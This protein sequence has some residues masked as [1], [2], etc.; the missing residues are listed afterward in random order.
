MSGLLLLDLWEVD[1]TVLAVEHVLARSVERGGLAVWGRKL[2]VTVCLPNL[3]FRYY[4]EF[5]A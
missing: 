5:I 2:Q 4:T 3:H 1:S